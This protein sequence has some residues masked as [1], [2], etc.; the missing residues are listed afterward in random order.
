MAG[1]GT[2]G[3]TFAGTGTL[4]TGANGGGVLTGGTIGGPVGPASAGVGVTLGEFTGRFAGSTLA[5]AGGAA[6]GW[7]ARGLTGAPHLLQNATPAEIGFPQLTQ[8][9]AA[10]LAGGLCGAPQELQNRCPSAIADPQRLQ[11]V[12]IIFLSTNPDTLIE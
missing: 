8:N 10:G 2:F 12:L 5:P 4:G 3:D 9:F 6:C 1:G 11:A 7:P